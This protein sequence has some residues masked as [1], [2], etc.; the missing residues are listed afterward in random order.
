MD[1]VKGLK[2]ISGTKEPAE[3]PLKLKKLKLSFHFLFLLVLSGGCRV[4]KAA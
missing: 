3:P 2:L 4:K 1:G